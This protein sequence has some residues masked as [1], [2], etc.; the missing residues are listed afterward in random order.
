MGKSGCFNF[1]SGELAWT[2]GHR[3]EGSLV[4]ARAEREVM[5]EGGRREGGDSGFRAFLKLA[6]WREHWGAGSVWG[7]PRGIG[8]GGPRPAT[9][10][11]RH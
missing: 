2:V 4:R 9:A 3:R 5:L 11:G 1:D 6:R 8:W 7:T 10:G